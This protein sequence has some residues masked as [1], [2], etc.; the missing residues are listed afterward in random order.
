VSLAPG[1]RFGPYEI[2]ALLGAGGMGEVHRAR[3]S[4][5]KRDVA[6]K[7]LPESVAHEPERFERFQREAEFLATLNHPNIAAVY[8]LEQV[9]G[10]EGIVLELVEGPTLEELLHGTHETAEAESLG[11]R[12]R[13]RIAGPA[14]GGGAPRALG[15]DDALM[16][17]RQI[18]DALEAAHERGII[19]RD[20]KANVKVTRE[21]RRRFVRPP[22]TGAIRSFRRTAHDWLWT[23]SMARRPTSGFTNRCATH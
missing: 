19:H 20:L 6:I 13:N 15:I 12:P 11:S 4:R 17:A 8:G 18:A 22:R 1:T 10:V 5:L 9:D 2:Q 23:S 16:I 3:D 14:R 21:G 7:V